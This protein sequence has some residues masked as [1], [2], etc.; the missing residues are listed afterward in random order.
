MP[1]KEGY[2]RV[3]KQLLAELRKCGPPGWFGEAVPA[4]EVLNPPWGER[5]RDSIKDEYQGQASP[6]T[7][8][9]PVCLHMCPASPVS[10]K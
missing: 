5:A 6:V 7:V 8:W 3:H 1:T 2:R 10:V 9:A 4:A